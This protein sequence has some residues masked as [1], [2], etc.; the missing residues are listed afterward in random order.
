MLLKGLMQLEGKRCLFRWFSPG[1]DIST[2]TG[3]NKESQSRAFVCSVLGPVQPSTH[4]PAFIL[5]ADLLPSPAVNN[6]PYDEQI[7]SSHASDDQAIIGFR[8]QEVR[9]ACWTLRQHSGSTS[10]ITSAWAQHW[11]TFT[12][13][14]CLYMDQEA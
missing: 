6:W 3:L 5:S 9:P 12:Q 2:P 7:L 8:T 11:H 4:F 13:R 1:S 14:T 10:R